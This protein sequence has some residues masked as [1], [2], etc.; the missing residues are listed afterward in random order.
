MLPPESFL[1]ARSALMKKL[2]VDN[3]GFP[4]LI[5]EV[6]LGELMKEKGDESFSSLIDEYL[7]VFLK[8]LND[9]YQAA[10]WTDVILACKSDSSSDS[11][12]PN[13]YAIILTPMHPIR[14]A[15][16]C[17]TQKILKET[18]DGHKP[19]PAASI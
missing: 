9:D 3:D 19:C 8:W 11:L 4:T 13:P 12:N 14:L 7:K 1:N 15:W 2:S 18:L 10:V 16:H 6:K 5:E 17:Q